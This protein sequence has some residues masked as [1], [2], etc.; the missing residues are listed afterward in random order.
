MIRARTTTYSEA[1]LQAVAEMVD[2]LEQM[3]RLTGKAVYSRSSRHFRT[4]RVLN[5]A[6]DFNESCDSVK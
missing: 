6:V 3:V 2:G 4:I 1:G 5:R